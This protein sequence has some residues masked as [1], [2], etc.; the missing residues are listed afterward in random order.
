VKMFGVASNFRKTHGEAAFRVL[1]TTAF[2]D[3]DADN[4]G[5]ID[6]AEL[7][8][9]LSKLG[10]KLTESQAAEIVRTYDADGNH[11]LDEEEFLNLVAELIDGSAAAKLPAQAR[12]RAS[13]LEARGVVKSMDDLDFGSDDDEKPSGGGGGGGGSGGGG[14]GGGGGGGG[15]GGS[16]AAA[17]AAAAGV[18]S[19]TASISPDQLVRENAALKSEN[20]L[21]RKRVQAL[22]AQ[23]AGTAGKQRGKK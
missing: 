2:G 1:A 11:Q 19:S 7:K 6:I 20:A 23:L 22:E 9:T 13:Q 14:V 3:A 18:P 17:A 8:K 5:F 16:T 4:S 15:S 21:L 12:A 10:M